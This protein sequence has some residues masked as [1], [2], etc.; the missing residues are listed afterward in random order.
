MPTNR[1]YRCKDV[2]MLLASKTIL[3]SFRNHLTDLSVIRSNWNDEYATHFETKIDDATER[4]LG[5]DK[6]EVLR[7]A[8]M[9]LENIQIPALRDLSFVK[10]Q[11]EV[12]FKEQAGAILKKLG[13]GTDY[14]K[15]RKGDQEALIQLLFAFRKGMDEVLSGEMAEK[16]INPALIERILD[17][18]GQVS[19]A[20]VLQEGL[21]VTTKQVSEEA[22]KAF[23]E[24][25][26]EVIGI[27]KIASGYYVDEPLLKEEFTFS[28]VV[29][30]MKKKHRAEEEVTE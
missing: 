27:C 11:I 1:N 19:E 12:D 15:A 23:M 7:Q 6:K 14:K 29:G 16:G 20:N 3:G 25:Y 28:K 4:Y 17:Y 13:Y 5:L 30:K 8:T 21:K 2:E 9:Q 22:V 18:A 10:T 26:N 24:V